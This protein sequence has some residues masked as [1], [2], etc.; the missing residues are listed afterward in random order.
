MTAAYMPFAAK[1]GDRLVT[2]EMMAGKLHPGEEIVDVDVCYV[3]REGNYITLFARVLVRK[4]RV[5]KKK[6]RRKKR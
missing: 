2:V 3:P 4:K 1:R 6:V 5:A